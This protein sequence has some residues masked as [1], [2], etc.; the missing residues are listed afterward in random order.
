MYVTAV[1]RLVAQI[2][3][4][5]SRSRRVEVWDDACTRRRTAVLASGDKLV[6]LPCPCRTT[7]TRDEAALVAHS[8]RS[9]VTAPVDARV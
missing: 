3:T 6:V 8:C 7:S 5:Q 4:R 2:S 9:W 1:P